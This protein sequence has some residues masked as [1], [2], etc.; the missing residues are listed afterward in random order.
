MIND[1]N[2]RDVLLALAQMQKSHYSMVSAAMNELASLRETVRA[3]DPTFADVMEERRLHFAEATAAPSKTLQDG[4]DEIIR[5][6]KD[7]S[8]C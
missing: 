4:C 2:L 7:G 3:L 8:V 6:L 5:R 1:T